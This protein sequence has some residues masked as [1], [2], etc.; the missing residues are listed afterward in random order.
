[1]RVVNGMGWDTGFEGGNVI[2]F[3]KVYECIEVFIFLSSHFHTEES[4]MC[5]AT[6]FKRHCG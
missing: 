4:V 2:T 6:V 3:C 1:M 5:K